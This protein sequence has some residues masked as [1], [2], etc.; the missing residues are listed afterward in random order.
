MP[1]VLLS[2]G[3]DRLF[4]HQDLKLVFYRISGITRTWPKG[5]SNNDE[6]LKYFFYE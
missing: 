1:C 2:L 6:A 3:L 5:E 4:F